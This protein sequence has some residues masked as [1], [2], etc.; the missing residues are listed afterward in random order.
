MKIYK[1]DICSVLL[2]DSPYYS[3]SDIE[4]HS[5]KEDNYTLITNSTDTSTTNDTIQSWVS[6][7]DMHF[8]ECCW[9]KLE[10][11]KIIEERLRSK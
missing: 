1:C 2:D 11:A 3:I 6:Y 9:N 10:V 4:F 7:A 8:C 5:G